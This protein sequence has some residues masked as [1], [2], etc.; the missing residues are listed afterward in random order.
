MASAVMVLPTP[1]CPLRRSE[2]M[3]RKTWRR[4]TYC[5]NIMHPLPLP[6]MKSSRF[7]PRSSEVCTSVRV[8]SI[9]FLSAGIDSSRK[10]SG[11]QVI[12]KILSTEKP[13]ATVSDHAQSRVFVLTPNPFLEAPAVDKMAAKH[14]FVISH[15]K[16]FGVELHCLGAECQRTLGGTGLI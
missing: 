5:S 1:G 7:D 15:V 13:A 8:L 2:S 3:H 4:C 10:A 6:T 12:S 14:E 9:S 16:I 11:F